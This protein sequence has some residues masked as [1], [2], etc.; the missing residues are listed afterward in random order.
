MTRK[1]KWK[2]LN[3]DKEFDL[4]LLCPYW[5]LGIENAR[6]EHL[7]CEECWNKEYN[8]SEVAK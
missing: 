1:E 5:D 7:T 2:E 3:P 8:E 4:V 6:H